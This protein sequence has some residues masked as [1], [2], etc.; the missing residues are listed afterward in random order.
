M[1][2]PPPG[3]EGVVLS[4]SGYTE[5][6]DGLTV[7]RELPSPCVV[8]VIELGPPIS[9][10]DAGGA[11]GSRRPGGFVAGVYEGLSDTRHD[12]EQAGIQLT[13]SPLGARRLFGLPSSELANRAV[14]VVDLLPPSHRDLPARLA[15]LP[16]WHQR[17]ER[18]DRTL[19]SLLAPPG[20]IGRVVAWG[21]QRI[22]RS[23]GRVDIGGLAREL[24]YSQKHTVRL[25]RDQVGV[26][27]KRLARL[28]RFDGLVKSVRSGDH[29]WGALAHLHGFSDQPHL[30]REVKRFTGWTPTA[31]RAA[32]VPT[33]GPEASDVHFVQ[34][35]KD[36]PA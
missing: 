10:G 16:T 9:V 36:T 21:M 27:P 32:L 33:F 28:V 1:R 4:Y 22:L 31:L 8:C 6:T 34:D 11:V 30:V 18:L 24:G 29:D 7:R 12:G 15:E 20:D 26:A 3:L 2:T 19:L 14:S 17:F 5:R 25:F 35:A 23:G 13:L